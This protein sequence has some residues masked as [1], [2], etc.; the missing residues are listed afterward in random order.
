[1]SAVGIRQ[2]YGGLRGRVYSTLIIFLPFL[3]DFMSKIAG[4]QEKGAEGWTGD[5]RIKGGA[6]WQQ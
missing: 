6:K 2:N 5:S 1:M 4:I 3:R